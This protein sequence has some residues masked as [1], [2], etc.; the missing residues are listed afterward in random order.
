MNDAPLV[1]VIIPCYRQAHYLDDA[2]QSVLAQTYRHFELIVIDD[3]SPDNTSEV[4]ARYDGVKCIRQRN[5]GLSTARNTGLQ[6]SVGEPRRL[7]R[8][9]RP[10]FTRRPRNR[11]EGLACCSRVRLRLWF[12]QLHRR[13]R[14]AHP[15]ASPH[16]NHQ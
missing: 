12:L 3:G 7:F 5:L 11:S 1:S 8:R 16:H 13:G 14:L 10:T 2:I 15:D 6:A 9:R 4:A